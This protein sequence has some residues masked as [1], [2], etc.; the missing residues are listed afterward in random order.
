MLS[1]LVNTSLLSWDDGRPNLVRG[2][3]QVPTSSPPG[4]SL[5]GW[6][7]WVREAGPQGAVLLVRWQFSA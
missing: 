6:G 4:W 7:Q 2:E 1:R 3:A 5:G